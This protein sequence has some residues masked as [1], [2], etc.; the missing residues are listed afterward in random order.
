MKYFAENGCVIMIYI[1]SFIKI[2]SGIQKMIRERR[3]TDTQ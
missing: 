3:C 1:R 2:A